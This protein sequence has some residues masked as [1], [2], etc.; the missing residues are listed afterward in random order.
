MSKALNP[1][2]PQPMRQTLSTSLK[3]AGRLHDPHHAVE[4]TSR[5][6]MRRWEQDLA[7][8]SPAGGR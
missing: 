6:I 4:R 8:E 7:N 1:P 5:W 3:T 2:R